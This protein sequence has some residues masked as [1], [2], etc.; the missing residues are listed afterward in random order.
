MVKRAFP[1]AVLG[2]QS[3]MGQRRLLAIGSQCPGRGD[4]PFLPGLIEDFYKAMIDPDMGNCIPVFDDG[5]PSLLYNPS[6]ADFKKALKTAFKVAADDQSTLLLTFLGHAETVGDDLYLLPNDAGERPNSDEAIHLVNQ[7]LERFREHSTIDGLVVLLD[8]CFAGF[9]AKEAASKWAG[10]LRGQLRY[11]VLTS[12]GDHPAA[13]GCFTKTL[14]SAMRYGVPA[15][16]NKFLRCEDL[17]S[18]AETACP[19]QRPDHPT[20]NAKPDLYI[21]KNR[22][23]WTRN[24]P[25]IDSIAQPQ[26]EKLT[27]G[28]EPTSQLEA[29]VQ[30]TR[31]NRLTI[32]EGDVGTG[33]STLAAALAYPGITAGTVPEMFVQA[34]VF[35]DEAMTPDILAQSLAKQLIVSVANFDAAQKRVDQNLLDRLAPTTGADGDLN[36]LNP[37]YRHVFA[38]LSLVDSGRPIR[39]VLDGLDCLME[40]FRSQLLLLLNQVSSTPLL[41]H[42][43]V[44]L[45]SRPRYHGGLTQA[46]LIP[47]GVLDDSHLLRY[48]ARKKIPLEMCA[49]IVARSRNNWLVTRMLGERVLLNPALRPEDLSGDMSHLYDSILEEMGCGDADVWRPYEAILSVLAAAAVGP[50]LPIDL[51]SQASGR[52]GG[53]SRPFA[54]R[55][56]LARSRSLLIRSEAG[57]DDEWCGLFH[58]TFAEY[59]VNPKSK[60][61]VRTPLAHETVVQLLAELAPAEEHQEHR[62]EVLYRYAFTAEL[63]HLWACGRYDQLLSSLQNRAPKTTLESLSRYQ[64][65]APRITEALG[66]EHRDTLTAQVQ[67]ALLTGDLGNAQAARLL[68]QEVL[69]TCTDSLGTDD[70]LTLQV[71]GDLGYFLGEEGK[72]NEALALL[73][74]VLEDKLRVF[75]PVHDQTIETRMNVA[76]WTGVTGKPTAAIEQLHSILD[77]VDGDNY[78]KRLTIRNNIAHWTGELGNVQGALKLYD[79]LLTDQ[80]AALGPDQEDTLLTRQNVASWKREA[81][82]T[83][84]ALRLSEGLLPDRLRV[85]GRDHPH[86]LTTRTAIAVATGETGNVERALNLLYTLLRDMQRVQ[87]VN[88]QDTLTMRARIAEWTAKGGGVGKSLQ[89]FEEVLA[90]QERILGPDHPGTL[91]TREKYASAVGEYVDKQQALERFEDNLRMLE[92]KR[93][94]GD[95]EVLRARKF[96]ARYTGEVGRKQEA[97]ELFT[98]LLE[99]EKRVL[100]ADHP[101]M[102]VAR[103]HLAY[104][105]H[106]LLADSDAVALL[107][108]VIADQERILGS[109][110]AETVEAKRI[111]TSWLNK[112]S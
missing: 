100:S 85:L 49:A 101:E 83:A 55:N 56:S 107:R 109:T 44:L 37:L 19:T 111:L 79:S 42:V 2:Q 5:S 43:H 106:E 110:H 108:G 86:T 50:N 23:I 58:Q 97:L 65:W 35:L 6:V 103:K 67:V 28:F 72:D 25:W 17:H 26:I 71:R 21:A 10:P 90:D 73:K 95:P 57:T 33:K 82:L 66:P 54:V 27:Q 52:M 41:A 96:V 91:K 69:P 46:E 74:Q 112:P 98:Q 53:P 48:L 13:D 75:G 14:L 105:K 40:E 9:G 12:S 89:L 63:D 4:L 18:I 92:R 68:L 39:L 87:G 31:M 60:F 84:E 36:S 7:I 45:T 24:Q 22:R 34:V 80:L 16:T 15:V 70:P 8:T 38:P 30:G 3:I 88:D 76:H 1:I 47:L 78:A 29:M 102:L 81:G 77:D 62:E 32:A 93:S 64:L 20:F 51:L 11:E 61:R 59:L 99:D 94:A 104:L